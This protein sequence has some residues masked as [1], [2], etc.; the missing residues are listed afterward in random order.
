M[1]N[2]A[3]RSVLMAI[4]AAVLLVAGMLAVTLLGPSPA[5]VA[6]QEPSPVLQGEMSRTITVVGEGRVRI[7]PDIAQINIGIEVVGETVKEASSQVAET[8][9][10]VMNAL[11]EGG[12]AEKDMQTSGYSVWVERPYGPE[13]PIMDQ[14]PIY[15]VNN[16]VN[17]T[18]RDLTNVG[19]VLDAAIEAGANNIYGVTF[20]IADPKPLQAEAREKA[21]ADA[22]AKAEELAGLNNVQLGEVV[23]VSEVIGGGPSGYYPG[24]ARVPVAPEGMGGGGGGPIS[25]GE[26]EMAAQLQVTYAI[27]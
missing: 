13:G 26:L 5:R 17:V 8:M 4:T 21:V 20:S 10:A 24:F 9:T 25:P 3:Q 7:Q 18:I 2:K 22:L 11:K 12:V 19:G 16:T 14:A 15:H 6:A 27:E 1:S 23:S